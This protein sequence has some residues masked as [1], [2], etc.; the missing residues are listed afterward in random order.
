[1]LSIHGTAK[2]DTVRELNRAAFGCPAIMGSRSLPVAKE[3]RDLATE[4][5]R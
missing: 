3:L 4:L 1:M 5:D 2:Q